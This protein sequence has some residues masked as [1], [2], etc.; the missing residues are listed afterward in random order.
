VRAGGSGELLDLATGELR[1]DLTD[2]EVA[3]VVWSMNSAEFHALLVG[4]R[5]RTTEPYRE[6]QRRLDPPA[7]GLSVE[8]VRRRGSPDRNRILPT[9]TR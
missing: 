1:A 4:E 5:G 8:R 7:A 6:F 3:D 9:V 2:D